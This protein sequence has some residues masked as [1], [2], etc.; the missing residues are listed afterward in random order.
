M[1]NRI[2]NIAGYQFT[3]VDDVESTQKL[4]QA[5]CAQAH[6]KGS[7]FISSEGINLSLAGNQTD[8]DFI[9]E[10][11]KSKCNFNQLL[12]NTS[13]SEEIP[14]KRLL[15]KKRDELVP[16]NKN[17]LAAPSTFSENN[18]TYISSEQLK[19]WLDNNQDIILI[20]MRNTFEYELGSFDKAIHLGLQKFRELESKKNT[21]NEIPK[22]KAIVTFCTGGIRCEKAA[23]FVIS[24]GFKQVYQLKGGILDYL[25][26]FKDQHWRG[27]CFVFDNRICL[28]KDLNPSYAKLC[29]SCQTS[30][31]DTEEK[32]CTYCDGLT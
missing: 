11:L 24:Q 32:F 19:L 8:I 15:I 9:L 27:D 20:D 12:I 21:L 28:D 23:P 31:S 17:S 2:I 5:I 26:K 29:Q 7:I 25:N 18:S 14:F 16:T 4:L 10:S 30:L 6:L 13:Y 22:D 3:D 1:L